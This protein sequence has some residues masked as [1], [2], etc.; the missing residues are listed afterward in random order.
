[1]G[2]ERSGGRLVVVSPHLDD[3]ALGCGE[4][5]ARHPGAVVIT[6]FAG[7]PAQY[8]TLTGWD[9]AAGF[10]LGD[11]VVAARR[12]EDA[13]ALAILGARPV[14]LDFLDAQYAPSPDAAA[15]ADALARAIHEV[16]GRRVCMPLG[17]F[18]SDH[19]LTTRACLAA[20]RRVHGVV[21]LAY[22]DALYRR[23][24]GLL[25]RRLGALR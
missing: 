18:H 3:A 23:T 12:A 2:D 6:V 7:R 19:R 11:D 13:A 10:G 24:P 22:A 1:M 5:L 25:R 20:M 14:W 16:R 17:L 4:L 9:A 21:W 8:A 15:I